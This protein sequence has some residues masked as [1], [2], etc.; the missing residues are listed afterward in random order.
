MHHH[1]QNILF[2]IIFP[3]IALTRNYFSNQRGDTLFAVIFRAKP[4]RYLPY[5]TVIK[6]IICVFP[7]K[8][9]HLITCYFLLFFIIFDYSYYTCYVIQ[10]VNLCNNINMQYAGM[11]AAPRVSCC[12]K[13][14]DETLARAVKD[15]DVLFVGSAQKKGSWSE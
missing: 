3:I 2:A 15:M 6:G 1:L 14:E 11:A 5:Q 9:G 10:C 12:Q 13:I 7:L 8:K 4:L